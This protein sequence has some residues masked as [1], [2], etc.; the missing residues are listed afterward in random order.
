MQGDI[1]DTG[2]KGWW[3]GGGGGGGGGRVG[4]EELGKQF[5]FTIQV[6]C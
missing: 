1:G 4:G 6:V 5:S 3:G 2:R